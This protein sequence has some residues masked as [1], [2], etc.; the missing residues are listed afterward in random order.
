MA[1]K[2]SQS[3]DI[4]YNI[5]SKI[6]IVLGL[7]L[8]LAVNYLFYHDYKEE[9][10]NGISSAYKQLNIQRELLDEGMSLMFNSVYLQRSW[11]R[12]KLNSIPDYYEE[13][14][15][16]DSMV[17]NPDTNIS[18]L[19]GDIPED[20]YSCG[21]LFI[22]GDVAN[23]DLETL[24]EI[25]AVKDIF[26]L[27]RFLNENS[28][29]STWSTYYTRN[30]I[31]IYPFGT[32]T[33]N[34]ISENELFTAIDQAIDQLNYEKS[35]EVFQT[36][37]ETDIF[38]DHTGHMLMFSKNL[39]VLRDDEVRGI[40]AV[41]ISIDDIGKYIKKSGD[42][43]VYITD[44]SNNV[45]Y[46]NGS[47]IGNIQTLQEVFKERYKF[48]NVEPILKEDITPK[49]NSRYFLTTGLQNAKWKLIY[50]VPESIIESSV[51]KRYSQ[52]ATA[53][54]FIILSIVLICL[55]LS[56]YSK[57]AMEIARLKDVF[58]MTVSHDLKSPLSSIIGF[59]EM[60]ENKLERTVFPVI[61]KQDEKVN[62]AIEQIRRDSSIIEKEGLRLTELIDNLLDLSSLEYGEIRLKKESCNVE[63]MIEDGFEAVQA[64]IKSKGLDY[65]IDA[66]PNLPEIFVDRE[67]IIQ[68]LVNL[69]ANA[70]KFT[71][72][73]YIKCSAWEDKDTVIFCVEDTGTGI[74]GKYQDNIFEKFIK[75]ENRSGTQEGTGLGLAICKNIAEKHGGK[76]W[77]QS[78]E[79]KGSKFF[80][81]LPV[82]N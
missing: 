70:V 29:F 3:S 42:L 65:C 16:I 55:L 58:L 26:S 60:I 18:S 9:V 49:I 6:V 48:S 63:Q 33:Q 69:L 4:S 25:E 28:S 73:G 43:E 10:K 81:S 14:S 64:L 44:S 41:N 27:Q 30:Y 12:D 51:C 66:A 15:I 68:L 67:K 36:G 47:K 40:I 2:S 7:L 38:F 22:H 24:K 80:F 23:L 54:L 79:G 45:V 52:Y 32:S 13:G 17:Y 72:E 76:M 57:K 19:D 31:T 34:I 37:W 53:N 1:K 62:R 56:K 11:I 74:A 21:N 77:L 50:A 20:E 35:R 61:D 71:Q 39:P 78:E 46:C 75:A 5:N 82:L 59:N 8:L